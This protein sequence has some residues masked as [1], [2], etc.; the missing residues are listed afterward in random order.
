MET[1]KPK[2]PV[3]KPQPKQAEQV[4]K[5]N[6]KLKSHLTHRPFSNEALF[7][8]LRKQAETSHMDK[9]GDK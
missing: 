3:T 2:P 7:A 6:F 4:K 1:P 8:K 5:A 9:E